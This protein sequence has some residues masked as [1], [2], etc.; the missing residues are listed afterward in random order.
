MAT[1]KVGRE[2]TYTGALVK[3]RALE[4]V[5]S[6]IAREETPTL[7]IVGFGSYPEGPVTNTKFEWLEDELI[8]Y[9]DA[10]NETNGIG[11]TDTTFAV[12]HAAYF[13]LGAILKVEDELMWVTG[14]DPSNNELHVVRG[15]AGTTAATHANDTEV[16]M[17][18]IARV[19]G[20]SPGVARQVVTTQPWNTVQIFSDVV[21]ITGSEA[22]MREYGVEDVL[23][24]RMDKRMR[25]MK[26]LME[27]S[28]LHGKRY[29]PSD[30]TTARTTGGLDQFVTDADDWG[31]GQVLYTDIRDAFKNAYDRV[32]AAHQPDTLIMNSTNK[33]A[34]TAEFV[35]Q[36]DPSTA[37]YRPVRSDRAERIAGGTITR[38]EFDFGVL[39]IVL[40]HLLGDNLV[41][42]INSEYVMSTW[43]RGRELG[44]FDATIPGVDHTRRRVLGELG[45]VVK[46]EKCHVKLYT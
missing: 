26:I 11:S 41:W 6:L 9:K 28:L 14:I 4:N 13:V 2:T 21:E 42:L 3:V 8:P 20:S 19:E 44:E 5:I 45:W 33:Q 22:A 35:Y 10:I 32:G 31:T 30:N 39:D 18:G 16:K 7:D 23:N 37:Q 24:Y 36:G 43:L 17:V 25:E 1:T 38:L 46:N 40:D 29:L 27:L 12:D 34:L 15:Y